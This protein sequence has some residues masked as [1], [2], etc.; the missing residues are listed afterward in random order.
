MNKA[1][2]LTPN[3]PLIHTLFTY[4]KWNMDGLYGLKFYLSYMYICHTEL[5]CN[6]SMR[7]EGHLYY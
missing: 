6:P 7:K 2:E 1:C 5:F 3:T 4:S